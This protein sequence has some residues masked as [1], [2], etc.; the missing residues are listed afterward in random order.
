MEDHFNKILDE[1]IDR[2]NRGE[3]I[4]SCLA[5]YPD[6]TERLRP[7]LRAMV[8]A[9]EAYSFMPSRSAKMASRERFYAA[10]EDLERRR[11]EKKPLF[12]WLQGWSRV[13]A[14][15]AAVLLIAVIG[16]F[17]IKPALLPGEPV[18]HPEPSTVA[19]SLEPGPLPV[20]PGP[21]PEPS[22]V[23]IVAKPSPEGNFVFLISDDVN[24]IG[25]FESVNVSISKISLLRSGDSDQ[26]IE[27]EPELGDVDLTLVQGDKTQEIWRGNIP[28]GEY[29]NVSIQVSNVRGV[30]KETNK[31][32]EIKLPSQKLHISKRFQ[33]SADALTAFTYDLTVVATGNL[34]SGIKYILKPQV[35]QSGAD[36]KPV[37]PKEKAKKENSN[38]KKLGIK[39]DS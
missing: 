32:V 12:G 6:Y 11:E 21:Q 3:G 31:E 27:F 8:T 10:V 1:C 5:D 29:T 35:D 7:L 34:Q 18:P 17:G 15:A 14:T 23:L 25:D 39:E 13:W 4:D 33:V 38:N 28:E 24:A 2:I 16:Y 20:A 19:P 22:P 30:L 36:H 37:E 9:R 26:S